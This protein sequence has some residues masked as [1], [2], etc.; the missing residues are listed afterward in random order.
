MAARGRES[1]EGVVFFHQC[2][3]E[4]VQT[5]QGGPQ[6]LQKTAAESSVCGGN[7][8][9]KCMRKKNKGR[10]L[11]PLGAVSRSLCLLELKSHASDPTERKPDVDFCIKVDM[12]ILSALLVLK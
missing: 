2:K 3:R 12:F 1:I 10:W 6:K 8:K 7:M 11:D 4:G 5:T 9:G